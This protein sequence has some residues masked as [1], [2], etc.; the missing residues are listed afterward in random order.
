MANPDA[1]QH[2]PPGNPQMFA[3]GSGYFGGV[4]SNVAGTASNTFRGIS[5]A[6]NFAISRNGI[7]YGLTKFGVDVLSSVL[8]TLTMGLAGGGTLVRAAVGIGANALQGG[9]VVSFAQRGN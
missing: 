2:G 4:G 9:L 3:G 7:E 6:F 5:D 8:T 1:Y